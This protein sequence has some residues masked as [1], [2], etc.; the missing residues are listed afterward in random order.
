VDVRLAP[1]GAERRL[2]SNEAIRG[3][4]LEPKKFMLA[5]NTF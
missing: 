2:R 4:M 5:Q 3:I 1:T